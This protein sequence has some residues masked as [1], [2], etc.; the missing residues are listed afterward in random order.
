[1]S[2]QE[3][4]PAD[5]HPEAAL[6]P[7]FANNTLR[8]VDRQLVA[9]HLDACSRCRTELHELAQLR[10]RLAAVYAA[11]PKPSSRIAQSVLNRI[12][13]ETCSQQKVST[14]REHWLD[15]LDSWVRSLLAP[16]WVPSLVALVLLSQ[17][18]LLLWATMPQIQPEQVTSRSI[19][20]PAVRFSVTFQERATEEHIRSMLKTV[21]G[22]VI[23]GPTPTGTY[24]IEVLAGDAETIRKKLEMIRGQTDVIR[25]A[26]IEKS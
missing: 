12:A 16:R 9:N 19:A 23:D 21:Q 1:M 18:G 17:L 14:K 25:S 2:E 15:R 8:E 6:L 24:V 10:T 11:E 4:L 3:M 22:R 5:V 7:W 13:Q 20:T 26:D